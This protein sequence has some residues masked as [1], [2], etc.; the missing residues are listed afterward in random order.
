MGKRFNTFYMDEALF[1]LL[2]ELLARG[3]ID[4]VDDVARQPQAPHLR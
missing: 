2:D 3:V 4:V 1:N